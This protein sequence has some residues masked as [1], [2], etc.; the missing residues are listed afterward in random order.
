VYVP[1]APTYEA[2][3]G[4][5]PTPIAFVASVMHSET[6][7]KPVNAP[8]IPP[9]T[10]ELPPGSGLEL[11]ET[12]GAAAMPAAEEPIAPRQKRVRPPRVEVAAEPLE[13]VETQ[14]EPPPASH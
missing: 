12:R 2:P 5:E 14:K 8:E 10:G 7:V 13:M 11:V 1:A 6:L 4:T 9:V 3:R